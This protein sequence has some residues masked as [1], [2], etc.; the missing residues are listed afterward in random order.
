MR[1]GDQL[2]SFTVLDDLG[3]G[4]MNE[5][6]LAR[7][8]ESGETVALKVLQASH[9]TDPN[10]V[11]RFVR[12]AETYRKLR[13]PNIVRYVG[14]GVRDQV[15]FIAIEHVEGLS[16][17][18]LLERSGA[19]GVKRAM[20]IGGDLLRALRHAHEHGIIHRDLKPANVMISR[21]GEVKLVDFGVARAEDALLETRSGDLLGSYQYS[22]PEQ[23]EGRSVD[24][25]SD[26]YAFGLILWETLTGKRCLDAPLLEVRRR[27]KAEEIRSPSSLTAEVPPALDM[28]CRR[29][30]RYRP[31]ERFPTAREA[32]EELQEFLELVDLE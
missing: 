19:L 22:S 15:Y 24:V 25:R 1:K 16:L 18:S 32:L 29:L 6:Y 28:I 21:S 2:G 14:S 30:L 4:G 3:A 13:H 20:Q 12:E 10:V 26:L 5:V 8:V 23:N 27:Q 7:D 11:P 31:D 17:A 9:V